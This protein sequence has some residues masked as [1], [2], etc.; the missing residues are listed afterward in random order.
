MDIV[1]NELVFIL[2][3][4]APWALALLAF[5]IYRNRKKRGASG[6]AEGSAAAAGR[7]DDD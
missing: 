7:Q 1:R 2:I 6:E 3:L 5:I 4:V